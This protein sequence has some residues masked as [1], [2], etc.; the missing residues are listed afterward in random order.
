MQANV[1]YFLGREGVSLLM[2]V[3]VQRV[4]I[5]PQTSFQPEI[6]VFSKQQYRMPR[7]TLSVCQPCTYD[8]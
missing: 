6:I 5:L 8:V 4:E 7:V 2:K 1:F 3:Q